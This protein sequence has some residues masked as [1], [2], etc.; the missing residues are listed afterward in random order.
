MGM[1]IVMETAIT[2]AAISPLAIGITSIGVGLIALNLSVGIWLIQRRHLL[3][4][5]VTSFDQEFDGTIGVLG[6][7]I[8]LDP[9]T[10]RPEWADR[11]DAGPSTIRGGSLI[12]FERGSIG[13]WPPTGSG[14]VRAFPSLEPQQHTRTEVTSRRW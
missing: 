8:C 3:R 10:R 2:S 11:A 5:V 6:D 13:G 1:D 9:A 12:T 14:C 4:R 7:L